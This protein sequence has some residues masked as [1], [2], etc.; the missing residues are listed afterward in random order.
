MGVAPGKPE[1]IRD[2]RVKSNNNIAVPLREYV[3]P[4]K[5]LLPREPLPAYDDAQK[6]ADYV[7]W[8]RTRGHRITSPSFD[9]LPDV[10]EQQEHLN[11]VVNLTIC[12][13]LVWGCAHSWISSLKWRTNGG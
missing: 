4:V 13:Q 12:H 10:A 8:T 1:G 6:A 5:V 7:L 9:E 11:Q 2:L 3:S